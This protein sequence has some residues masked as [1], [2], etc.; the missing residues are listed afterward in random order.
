MECVKV[1]KK[2]ANDAMKAVTQQITQLIEQ[3]GKTPTL[4]VFILS[5]V[6]IFLLFL[7]V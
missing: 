2:Y 4:L 3:E 1:D 7:V 6:L 5:L